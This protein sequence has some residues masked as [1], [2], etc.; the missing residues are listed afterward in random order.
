[1]RHVDRGCAGGV[2]PLPEY[3]SSLQSAA[4]AYQAHPTRWVDARIIQPF[5]SPHI[6]GPRIGATIT[7][8]GR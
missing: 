6:C 3:C 8:R 5:R 1:M 2:H 7:V 4:E